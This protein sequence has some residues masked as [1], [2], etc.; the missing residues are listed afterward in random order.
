[1]HWPWAFPWLMGG[2]ADLSC[3][4]KT[5]IKD[6]GSFNGQTGEGRNIHFGV[7]EHAMGSIANGM[8]Y[9][10]GLIP[11][12]AT[13]LCFADYMR[14]AMRLAALSQLPVIFVFT[15]DS[16]GL[17]EDGPTHQPVE[18]V[19]SLRA[20]PNMLVIRPA[21]ATETAEA[22]RVAVSQKGR[23]TT[24]VFSRQK[25]PVLDRGALAGAKELRK[26]GYVAV[27]RRRAAGRDDRHGLGGRR[28]ARGPA[29]S[30]PPRA[31]PRASSFHALLRVVRRTER[32]L[33]ALRIADRRSAGRHRGGR[34]LW[35]GALGRGLGDNHWR[36]SFRRVRA[37]RSGF[38]AIRA[39][40]GS[41][42]RN[43]HP[44]Y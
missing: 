31:M 44:G 2:D 14:P 10:R 22:W 39:G 3:S 13:F 19:A 4:T 36:R 38:G 20:M 30:P 1:M 21:D 40:P 16:I 28:R 24:L 34:F 23:P 26:G 11:F 32:R 35:M 7:R 5:T 42:I 15:H 41:R 9:H 33:S 18:H 27:R 6:S 8:A 43:G 37:R 25:L 12:T 29:T 17:G